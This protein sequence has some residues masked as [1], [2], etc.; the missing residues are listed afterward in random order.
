MHISLMELLTKPNSNKP[1]EFGIVLASKRRHLASIS[2]L[3][4]FFHHSSPGIGAEVNRR[5]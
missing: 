2:V 3:K 5:N 1:D 4:A